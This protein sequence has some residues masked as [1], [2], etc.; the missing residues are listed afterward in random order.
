LLTLPKTKL[1]TTFVAT[2]AKKAVDLQLSSEE[3]SE[4][5]KFSPRSQ[6]PVGFV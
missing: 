4:E 2:S 3:E 5:Q 1:P 6:K